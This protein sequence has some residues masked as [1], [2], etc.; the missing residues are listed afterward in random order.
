MADEPDGE[1]PDGERPDRDAPDV[2]HEPEESDRSAGSNGQTAVSIR[3]AAVR[4]GRSE[5]AIYHLIAT[6]QLSAQPTASRGLSI[7]PND[8]EQ[9]ERR[10][11]G[12]RRSGWSMQSLWEWIR[13]RGQATVRRLRTAMQS[14]VPDT[15][16]DLPGPPW[17]W[18][19]PWCAPLAPRW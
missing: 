16:R 9:L 1:R 3:E 5:A 18:L 11:T 8:L 12:F 6:G 4:T 13:Q 2:G 14:P 19:M 10:G 17:Y 15:P 7:H